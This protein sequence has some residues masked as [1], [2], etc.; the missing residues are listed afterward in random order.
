M[1]ACNLASASAAS[2]RS[3]GSAASTSSWLI[4]RMGAS[5]CIGATPYSLLTLQNLGSMITK[6]TNR[7]IVQ[8]RDF[9][10]Y[11]LLRPECQPHGWLIH[12]SAWNSYSPK[13]ALPWCSDVLCATSHIHCSHTGVC[14][15]CYVAS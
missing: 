5:A 1:A 3:L 12:R 10:C 7:H 15:L 4:S 11:L 13:L 8:M 14:Y 9:C 2:W 6:T